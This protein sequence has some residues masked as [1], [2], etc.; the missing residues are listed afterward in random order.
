MQ[1]SNSRRKF[2]QRISLASGGVLLLSTTQIVNAFH[3]HTSP[4]RGYNPYAE[5]KT[6]MRTSLNMKDH[7]KI[8]G[9]VYTRESLKALPNVNLEVWHLSPGS[10]KYHHQTRLITNEE[11]EYIFHTDMPGKEPGK[12]PRIYFKISDKKKSYFTE[13]IL[14]SHQAHITGEHWIR[15]NRL[16][17]LMQ[18]VKKESSIQFNLSI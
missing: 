7:I 5:S 1:H 16:G 10:N 3:G 9:K 4:F 13:L 17:T 2:V 8:S 6:D 11:G 14:S 15:N 12:F 18:P